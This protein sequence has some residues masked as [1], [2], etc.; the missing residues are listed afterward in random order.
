M[1]LY[2]EK[3][4]FIVMSGSLRKKYYM[5]A[6]ALFVLFT[7]PFATFFNGLAGLAEAVATENLE[8]VLFNLGVVI[9][10]IAGIVSMYIIVTVAPQFAMV[11]RQQEQE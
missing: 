1:V 4:V 2:R 7:Y 5:V 11:N 6:V 3:L 10:G 8:N 9:Y